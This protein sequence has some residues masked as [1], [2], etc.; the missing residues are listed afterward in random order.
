MFLGHGLWF[1]SRIMRVTKIKNPR[2]GQSMM[3]FSLVILI[4]LNLLVVTYNAV[5]AFGVQQYFSYAAF[6]AARALEASSEKPEGQTD[7]AKKVMARFITGNQLL[8]GNSSRALA[9]NIRFVIPD[10]TQ[11]PYG[12]KGPAGD[13]EV[14]ISFDVPLFELPFF[15]LS[16]LF[17]KLTLEAKSY[18]GREPTRKECRKFFNDFYQFFLPPSIPNRGERGVID[19]WAG[20]DDNDC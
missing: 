12:M 15:S 11:I 1:R 18:L 6:M 8:F 4:F 17:P 2:R 20:M 10:A 3:E 5:L 19:A 7:R 16:D 14:K 9:T 13:R